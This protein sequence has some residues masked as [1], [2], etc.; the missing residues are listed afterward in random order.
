MA[1]KFKPEV[2]GQVEGAPDK[3]RLLGKRGINITYKPT[4]GVSHTQAIQTT[5]RPWHL[6]HSR[7]RT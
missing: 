2:F 4:V 1:A 7:S 6:R 3:K 5:L